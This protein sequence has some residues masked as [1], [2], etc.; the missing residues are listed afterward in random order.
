MARDKD[1]HTWREG[2]TTGS[3]AAGAAKAACL[4]LRGES[5]A[6][7]IEIP[8]PSSARLT[9]PI[10]SGEIHNLEGRA[11]ILKDGGDDADIT[12][13]LE[14]QALVRLISPQGEVLIRGGRGVGTVTKKGLAIPVGESAINPVPRRMIREAVREVFP[15]E[16]VEI[17]IEVPAGETT[18]LRTLNPRLGVIGGISILGTSGIVRPMSEEAF[19]TSILPELDQAVAYGYKAIV[20]TPGHYGFRVATEG[21][22]VPP[23]AVIQ[24][25][26][27]VGYMLEEAAYRGIEE[28]ILL[29]HVGKLIKVSAG[30]F[31][32]HNRV[33]DARME[34]LLAHAAL[35][36][37]NLD[38]LKYLAEFP[39]T[40]GAT[41]E[42]LQMGEQK[43]L[44]HLAHLASERAQAFTFG[45][46]SVGT[47]MTLLDGQPVG[48]DMK[49][50]R[51]VEE[52][53]WAWTSE[54]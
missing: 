14:I 36:G 44:H 22:K 31:H 3:C 40:E 2:Y 49:A 53:G 35:A 42:L 54:I 4:L 7:Q 27:F 26:N 5:L 8:L 38:S 29:G 46:L 32:T 47:I 18:A 19:K 43:L 39:T 17:T 51:I 9:M 23:E 30:I 12:H 50:R 6:E 20:L 45:R 28:V 24:M 1:R 16:E 25:S 21:F 15:V 34:I 52:Q 41:T 48:W 33:A 11:C 10:H 13:G 37:L